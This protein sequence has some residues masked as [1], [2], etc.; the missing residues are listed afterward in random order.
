[1]TRRRRWGRLGPGTGPADGGTLPGRDLSALFAPMS[2]AIVGAS[3]DPAKWG[4]AVARQALRSSRRPVHLVNHRG[5]LVHGRTAVTSVAEIEGPVDLAVICVPAAAFEQAAADCLAKGARALLAITAGLG[6]T[7]PAGRA[8]QE[9]V[10]RLARVAGAVLVG[11]NCLGVVDNTTELYLASDP[12]APGEV[13]LLS[14]SGNLA[15]ELQQLLVSR[16]LGFSRFVSL[17]NQADVTLTDVVADCAGHE[18]TRAIAMY[19]ED[20]GDGRGFVAAAAAAVEAGKPV[21]VLA[22]GRTAAAARSA[23]S[24]TGS[25]ATGHDVVAAACRAAGAH[26]VQTPRE[27]ADTLDL[28]SRPQRRLGPRLAIL[29]DGGGHGTISADLAADHGLQVPELSAGLQAALREDLWHRA[30]TS[31]PVDVAGYGEQDP[32]CFAR[33]AQRLLASGEVDAVLVTGYYGGYATDEAFSQGHAEDEVASTTRLAEVVAGQSLPLAAHSMYPASRSMRALREGGVP[34][35]AAVEDAIRALARATR[36]PPSGLL[37]LPEPGRPVLTDDYVASRGLMA[38][39][40]IPTV[41]AVQARTSDQLVAAAAGLTYPLVLK[42]NGLLHKS[43]QGGVR[44]GIRDEHEL[45]AAHA[46]MATRLLPASFSLEEQADTTDG[47]EL[48]VGARWDARFGPVVLVG[49]GGIYTELI[50]DT[51]L[52]LAPVT[53]AEAH[54]LLLRLRGA[55]LL[56]GARGRPAVALAAAAEVVARFSELAAA[57]PELAELELNPLLATPRGALALDARVVLTPA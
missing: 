57:H 15:L 44:L 40:G 43:D 14:Q 34:V 20:F 33:A 45:V 47:V 37:P 12:F 52:A 2:V 36:E 4:N 23:A 10:V 29:T 24:H 49:L 11:P 31:N 26:L 53:A 22:P 39:A 51:A 13:A 16:G 50:R 17:G 41:R 35:F 32:M 28:L 25:L 42:A 46:E 1:M 56:V 5:G 27:L 55:P 8:A 3:A 21:V 7:D 19:A 18:G 54:E 38:A 6:E 30:G 48:I 9:R